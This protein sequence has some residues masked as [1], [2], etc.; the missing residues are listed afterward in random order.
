[1]TQKKYLYA[2][3]ELL[4][5]FFLI[6]LGVCLALIATK[7]GLID[8]LVD[9]FGGGIGAIFVAGLFFTSAFTIAPAAVALVHLSK[10]FSVIDLVVVG[11]L[12][13]MVGDLIIFFFFRDKFAKD[14]L[15]SLKPSLLHHVV[16]TFH[17]GFLKWLGP[18][19]GALII[20]SPLPDELGLALMGISKTRSYILVPLSFIMNM[21]GI[22]SILYFAQSI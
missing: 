5:D 20:A 14:L 18:I 7:S 6:I 2:R 21:L 8:F 10:T 3:K 19:I 22:Y 9:M 13:A 4:K 16:K 12:G 11:A 1:M 17:F 15:S